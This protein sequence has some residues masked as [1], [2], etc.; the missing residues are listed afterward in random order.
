VAIDDRISQAVGPLDSASV[1]LRQTIIQ[2]SKG[3]IALNLAELWE[4]RDLL[5][6]MVWRDLKG[7]YRQTALGP[8][9]IVL[10]P[11]M[12]M[13]LY[14]VIFGAIAHLP[15]D[16]Q[17]YAV[18]TYVALLPWTFFTTAFGSG[19]NSISSGIGLSSKVYFPRLVIPISQI[20]SSLVDLGISFI[21]LAG[22]LIY[23]GIQ[24]TWGVFLIP[25]WLVLAAFTGLG[26]GLWFCGLIVKYRD[27][28]NV[29]SFL[30][31]MWMYATPVVYSISVVPARWLNYYRLNPM[32]VVTEG[33]RWALLGG[34]QPANWTIAVACLVSVPVLITGLFIFKRAER[35]IVDYA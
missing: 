32:T 8:L 24:P 19:T 33:F 4:F 13:V 29:T 35:N 7:R 23:Y 22:M 1:N 5:Y 31:R 26:V 12:S 18:F 28:S 20:M 15:S 30:N 16:N 6:Y 27:V 25:V 10:S 2:P 14:T 34:A 3:W 17:P 11:L 9:W 21:I